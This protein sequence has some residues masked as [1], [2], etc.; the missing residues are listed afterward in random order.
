[1][2]SLYIGLVVVC[3]VVI[4]ESLPIY[5]TEMDNVWKNDKLNDFF[6][7]FVSGNGHNIVWRSKRGGI[8]NVHLC[9]AGF[10]KL[11]GTGDCVPC[12]GYMYIII[13]SFPCPIAIIFLLCLCTPFIS[14]YYINLKHFKTQLQ[15]DNTNCDP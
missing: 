12:Y 13:K 14:F 5:R 11:Y 7:E 3:I 15:R 8:I 4:C 1:M 10:G 6:N 9:P 2:R